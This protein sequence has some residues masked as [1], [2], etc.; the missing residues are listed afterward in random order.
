MENLFPRRHRA[1]LVLDLLLLA[2]CVTI[3][4][5]SA[6]LDSRAKLFPVLV[7][8]FTV[9]LIVIDIVAQSDT[10]FGRAVFTFF[11]GSA[12]AE[13][14]EVEARKEARSI[15]HAIVWISIF[16]V[17]VWLFGFQPVIPVYMFISMRV[18][19]NNS[20]LR[21]LIT[22]AV[23]MLIIWVF[24]EYA[25]DYTLYRGLVAELIAD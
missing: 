5:L 23:I 25:L 21:S 24:F 20:T 10:G 16:V 13:D 17:A 1:S 9:A 11:S 19:G 6:G 2:F 14:R 15:V 4:A 12:E 8:W 7:G 18:F 3:I 22:T